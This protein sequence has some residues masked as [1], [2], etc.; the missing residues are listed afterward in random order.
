M[1]WNCTG[2]VQVSA[3]DENGNS[4]TTAYTDAYFWRPASA[5]DQLTN[6]A[7]I[8]Y[9]SATATEG[10]FTFN[11]N[12]S[13]VDGR[14]KV[15]GLGR[16]IV[17]QRRQGPTASNYDSVETDYDVAGHVSKTMQAYAASAGSLCSGT[18]P[19]TTY[20]YDGLNRPTTV[21]DASGETVTYSYTKNDVLQTIGPA[22]SGENTKRKQSEY[23]GL[24]RLISVCEV[25][26]ASG[27]GNC[28]QSSSLTGFWATYTYDQLN[29]L[30]GVT[31]NAQAAA[32]SRQS[33]SYSFDRV[34]RMTSETNPETGTTTYVYDTDAT[35]GTYAGN[36]VKRTDAVGNVTCYAY[37]SLH[38][39]T[40][41]TYPSGSYSAT[42]PK[43]Y[44]AY[45]LTTVNGNTVSNTK[46][47]LAEAYTCTGSCASKITDLWY[48]YSKRGE[49]TDAY[50]VTPHS[51]G[52]YHLTQSYWEHGG[53]KAL[54]GLPGLPTIT[55]GAADGT[56]LDGEGR[57]TKITAST[58]T[59]PLT[60]ATYVLTGTT[61][62]IGALTQ[63]TFGSAD[64][65]NF[66]YDSVGRVTQYK[67]N[68]GATP[69]SVIGN[70]AWNA[71]SNLKTLQI[72]DPFNAAN[73]QTCNFAYDDLARQST[74]NCGTAWNQ[75][76]SFDPFG[77][78]SK[79]ATVGT[80]FNA[81]YAPATNRITTIGSLVPTYDG[82]GNLTNDTSHAYT[83]DAEGKMLN[84]D[85]G[86]SS[87]VCG[88]YDA[89]GRMAEKA[90]GA[91]C[92]STYT[93]IVYAPSGGR[94]ATMTG[95]TL[96]QASVPL[97]NGTEAVYSSSGLLA[98]RHS[99]HLGSSRFAST[100]ARTKY[101][102]VAYA[103]YGED[104][105][106]SGT[107]D[108]SFT[109][110]KRD[111][112]SWLYDFMFRK[113]N[114]AHGRWMSPDPAGIGATNPSAPQTWNRYV[115]VANGPLSAV[116]PLGLL[117]EPTCKTDVTSGCGGG[118]NDWGTG[119]QYSA[120]WGAEGPWGDGS[121]WGN[122]N[123]IFDPNYNPIK[124]HA[125]QLLQSP[126]ASPDFQG[127]NWDGNERPDG[128]WV[129]AGGD[130]RGTGCLRGAGGDD[131]WCP[132][133]PINTSLDSFFGQGGQLPPGASGAAQALKQLAENAARHGGYP[134]PT[135]PR[136][137]TPVPYDP[138]P[139]PVPPEET[140]PLPW[141]MYI[142]KA[143]GEMHG[144]GF[145]EV[146]IFYI[147]P[148]R[149]PDFHCQYETCSS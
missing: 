138:T 23:D 120:D 146:P 21:T 102:D 107:A 110:Q 97:L 96:Q 34:G 127:W 141:W 131:V 46:G 81:T 115:Y 106:G 13:T 49:V 27:S 51:G 119:A 29:N 31:Q 37:D 137:P 149:A 76:F 52:T 145:V 108:L 70:L 92:T 39:A 87:G 124:T 75:T 72:T 40:S 103:P 77:N 19:G 17:G 66:S 47:R 38:R 94:L 12:T 114:S 91:T 140:V 28:A 67:F 36:L 56:G 129:P 89:L 143:I 123:S 2:G 22:P 69:Q 135:P 44:F 95:Q 121:S 11:G 148:P 55:Y 82:N 126:I 16:P 101:Y 24:G 139:N 26:S 85:S 71:N 63:L 30:T 42:T 35:C 15:D 134:K 104:Y 43:K 7:S 1:T 25:T 57:V 20:A 113:Y 125:G 132:S 118:G 74:A 41:I 10:T 117:D 109:G 111:T 136:V 65:D 33:R 147:P 105:A 53:L 3:T 83:W 78:I 79:S 48:S 58:G 64:T 5:T 60:S 128:E 62:P 8:A 32:P 98:Y 88:T 99:D 90:T 59:N 45:D 116:D 4:V 86:T 54:A 144:N 100:P 14:S 68:I 18:C 130:Y 122:G 73:A 133:N 93:E 84:I 61:Q 80:N 9:L 112:A 142:L 50:E 6:A